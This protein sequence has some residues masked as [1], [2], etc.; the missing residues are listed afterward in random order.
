MWSPDLK[1]RKSTTPYSYC[2]DPLCAAASIPSPS[3]PLSAPHRTQCEY[4]LLGIKANTRDRVGLLRGP[5]TI[6]ASSIQPSM[7]LL[8]GLGPTR[9][10]RLGE[11]RALRRQARTTDRERSYR[12]V[13]DLH[14]QVLAS[15]AHLCKIDV[16]GFQIA[17]VLVPRSGRWPSEATSHLR[18]C[19]ALDRYTF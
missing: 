18:G 19:I 12:R 9:A 3:S 15:R 5:W 1:A 11:A 2:L 16:R 4:I 10:A 13:C 6:P 17:G 7:L 14:M 8:Q